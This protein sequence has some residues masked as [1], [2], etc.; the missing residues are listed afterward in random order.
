MFNKTPEHVAAVERADKI[1]NR[2][3]KVAQRLARNASRTAPD[4]LGDSRQRVRREA[5]KFDKRRRSR[6]AGLSREETTAKKARSLPGAA[7]LREYRKT[8]T[9]WYKRHDM[10]LSLSVKKTLRQIRGVKN[11]AR[12]ERAE[13]MRLYL[14][15]RAHQDHLDSLY[16]FRLSSF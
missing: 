5:I 1:E 2:K 8:L 13:A 10:G 11:A 16:G 7:D 12:A 15:E 9:G 14:K 3:K 4:S 6:L